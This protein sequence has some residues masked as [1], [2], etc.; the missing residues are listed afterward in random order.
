MSCTDNVDGEIERYLSKIETC[1]QSKVELDAVDAIESLID[2]Q[3]KAKKVLIELLKK[4]NDELVV[5]SIIDYFSGKCYCDDTL[6]ESVIGK[7]ESKSWLIRAYAIEFLGDIKYK[8]IKNDIEGMISSADIEEIP[9]IYYT[10]VR[11]GDEKYMNK[12]I[13]ML[14]NDYYRVRIATAYLLESFLK[15]PDY[16][17]KIIK[18]LTEHENDPVTSVKEAVASILERWRTTTETTI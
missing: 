15:H 9:R 3:D 2:F 6:I 4:F 1:L 17:S 8:K 16:E 5:S 18:A 7:L 13:E 12:L 11:F 14:D 10:L